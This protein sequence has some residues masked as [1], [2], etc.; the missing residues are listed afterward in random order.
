MNLYSY[1]LSALLFTFPW[2]FNTMV[3]P[4]KGAEIQ[5]LTMEE[6]YEKTQKEPKKILVDV[7]TDWCGWCKV[8]DRGTFRDEK[9]VAYVNEHYYAVKFDAEQTKL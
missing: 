9:V 3:S 1:V 4:T 6:A 5:W 8:M 7:Y 2:S